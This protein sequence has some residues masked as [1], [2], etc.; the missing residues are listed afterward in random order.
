MNQPSNQ[1]T[2]D[3]R[4]EIIKIEMTLLQSR[5]D[6]YDDAIL[7]SRG[8]LVTIVT[9]LLGTT[10]T[11]K[12]PDLAVLSCVITVLFYVLEISWRMAYWYKYV[13]RYR[14]IR[15]TLNKQQSID[16]LPLYDLTNHH[17]PKTNWF[18]RFVDCIL[19]GEPLLFYV[20]LAAGSLC[21][22]RIIK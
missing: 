11:L 15:D 5:F 20:I 4:V 18:R 3:Q 12:T 14:L 1:L 13:D 6:K 2:S 8:W 7:R 9:A 19:W 16:S 17:S 22:L 21:I 10:L